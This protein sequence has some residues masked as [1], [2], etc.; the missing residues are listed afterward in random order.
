MPSLAIVAGGRGGG[1]EALGCLA[2]TELLVALAALGCS[3]AAAL[4]GAQ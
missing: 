1:V 4:F 3:A 2:A